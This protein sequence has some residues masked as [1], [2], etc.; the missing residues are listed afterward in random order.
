MEK[1]SYEK[2]PAFF[3]CISACTF[4]EADAVETEAVLGNLTTDAELDQELDAILGL[5]EA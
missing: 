2:K 5:Q 1:Y 3:R 4:F